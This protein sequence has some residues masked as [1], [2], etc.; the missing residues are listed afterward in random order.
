MTSDELEAHR[1]AQQLEDCRTRGRL[2]A[3]LWSRAYSAEFT[4]LRN[5]AVRDTQSTDIARAV[6][7]N[8]ANAVAADFDHYCRE[9]FA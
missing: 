5:G 1:E 7:C 8:V 4:G 9:H 2:R 6:A 3:E